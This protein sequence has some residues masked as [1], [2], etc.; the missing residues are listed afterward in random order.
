MIPKLVDQ[1]LYPDLK[2][3]C[4]LNDKKTPLPVAESIPVHL[5]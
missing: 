1:G 5:L 2:G 3:P 4:P